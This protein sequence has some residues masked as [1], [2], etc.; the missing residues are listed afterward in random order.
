MRREKEG[1]SKPIEKYKL[2]IKEMKKLLVFCLCVLALGACKDER[3]EPVA[4]LQ[5]QQNDSLQKILEQRDN[6]INDMMATLNEIQEGFRQINQAEDRVTLA[7]D[8]EGS[9]K[10]EQIQQNMQ[11]I[12]ERLGALGI[13]RMKINSMAVKDEAAGRMATDRSG[14]DR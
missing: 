8:G 11:F 13:W 4:N 14:K 2:T 9:N 5:T 3:K 12:Q 1:N 6:E 10:K 7:R